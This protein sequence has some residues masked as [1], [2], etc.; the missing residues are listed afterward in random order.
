M[1]SQ[2]F[3]ASLALK[4]TPLCS[5]GIRDEKFEAFNAESSC[6]TE[7]ENNICLPTPKYNRGSGGMLINILSK[8]YH[9]EIVG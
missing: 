1:Y 8:K 6:L 9:E 7:N 2:G 3:L 4:N 5:S